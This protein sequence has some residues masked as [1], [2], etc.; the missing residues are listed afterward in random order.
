VKKAIVG[1]GMA[2]IM[3]VNVFSSVDII[4]LDRTGL[5]TVNAPTEDT[6]IGN[7]RIW[8]FSTNAVLSTTT[9]TNGILRGGAII[10]TGSAESA[11]IFR[12]YGSTYGG[13]QI[14]TSVPST[15]GAG[16][17]GM[18]Y[19]DR[20]DFLN[21]SGTDI[22]GFRAGDHLDVTFATLSNGALWDTRFAI[23]ENG[24]WYVSSAAD[25]MTS[26]GTYSLDPTTTSWHELTISDGTNYN[27]ATTASTGLTLDNVQGV[28]LYFDG[29]RNGQVNLRID[30]GG[31]SVTASV[32]PE[33]ATVGILGLGGLFAYLMRKK[34][35]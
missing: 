3:A 21:V 19:W 5:S 23:N 13:L 12:L 30:G 9:G 34:I 35:W 24:N 27:I 1:I 2:L 25:S 7:A 16:I 22:V 15:T 4:T 28:G 8:N 33:P 31:F 26:G 29:T 11:V 32:I 10:D 20:S 18:I 17:L 6:K 14:S